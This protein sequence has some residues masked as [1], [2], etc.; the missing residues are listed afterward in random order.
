MVALDEALRTTVGSAFVNR[1]SL[2]AAGQILQLG[3]V[4]LG[5][6]ACSQQRQRIEVWQARQQIALQSIDVVA[7]V[8]GHLRE[9]KRLGILSGLLCQNRLV[10]FDAVRSL[11]VDVRWRNLREPV[12]GRSEP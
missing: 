3:Y 5:P 8:A 7:R 12:I 2:A 6:L 9:C 1:P 10:C 4:T 11:K